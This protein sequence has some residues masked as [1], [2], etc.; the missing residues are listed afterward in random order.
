LLLRGQVAWLVAQGCT[1]RDIADRL[2]I[3]ER[4]AEAHVSNL[5][6]KLNLR[7]RAQLAIWTMQQDR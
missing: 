3:S 7:S 1:N 6:F 5:L 4:T 2:V